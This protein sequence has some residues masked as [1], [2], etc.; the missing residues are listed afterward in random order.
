MKTIIKKYTVYN[1]ED[2]K[3]DDELC[4]DIYQ[5]FWLDNPNNINSWADENLDSFKKFAE[6][7][8]MSL[9]YCLSNAEYPCEGNYIK[10][11]CSDYDYVA[12]RKRAERIA[13]AIEGYKGNG[14]CFC[15]DLRIYAEKLVAEW[16]KD[17][18][19]TDFCEDMQNRM[20]ELWFKDNRYYF[21]KENFLEMV[22]TNS[23]EFDQDGNLV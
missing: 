17:Y 8:N 15:E 19:I 9:D 18:S 14:Y 2:L 1:F 20:E 22:E 5:E 13:N 11:D 6:T 7:I 4:N 10:L 21:S 12:P 3:K 23:Y 16:H